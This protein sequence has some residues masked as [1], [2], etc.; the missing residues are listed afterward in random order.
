MAQ[1][2]DLALSL[3]RLWSLLWPWF[4]P[5][6]RNLHM[7]MVQPKRKKRK[8]KLMFLAYLLMGLTV[9]NKKIHGEDKFDSGCVALEC[10]LGSSLVV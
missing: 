3:L 6:Q 8:E 2:V 4:D 7:S 10:I 5:W 1:L 9:T